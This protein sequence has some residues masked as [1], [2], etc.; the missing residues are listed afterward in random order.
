MGKE[1]IL[2][3]YI[4]VG[5][6]EP[7][8]IDTLTKEEQELIGFLLNAEGMDALGYVPAEQKQYEAELKRLERNCQGK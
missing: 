6:K 4:I 2:H 8:L 1:L 7:V 3:N 5:D